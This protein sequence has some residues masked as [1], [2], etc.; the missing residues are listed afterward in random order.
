MGGDCESGCKEGGGAFGGLGFGV[1]GVGWGFCCGYGY[2]GVSGF[3][4]CFGAFVLL[5]AK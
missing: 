3:L 2:E 5:V 1:V 4:H